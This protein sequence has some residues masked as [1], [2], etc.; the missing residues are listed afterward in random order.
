MLGEKSAPDRRFRRHSANSD[1]QARV[2]ALGPTPARRPAFGRATATGPGPGLP[3][4]L[5]PV[6]SVN[7]IRL[8]FPSDSKK[9]SSPPTSHTLPL[10]EKPKHK[11]SVMYRTV[12]SAVSTP[13]EDINA[14]TILQTVRERYAK[15]KSEGCEN[16]MHW[17]S[18]KA[19]A[20]FARD[21]KL[22]ADEIQQVCCDYSSK[23]RKLNL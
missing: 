15:W 14:L 21:S 16:Q 6:T 4:R 19:L 7:T 20:A 11:L 13:R 1:L 12:S 23:S 3:V 10:N 8:D 18:A 17:Y 5:A 2:R 22:F 9:Y